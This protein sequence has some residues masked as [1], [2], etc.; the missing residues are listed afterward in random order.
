MEGVKSLQ[1][2]DH[3]KSGNLYGS[4][5]SHSEG[6]ESDMRFNYCAVVIERV[7]WKCINPGV[8]YDPRDST[9]IDKDALLEYCRGCRC[10]DGGVGLVPGLESHGGSYFTCLAT[11]TILDSVRSVFPSDGDV[12]GMKRWGL[13]RQVKGMQGRCNKKEDTCYSYWVGGGI[14]LLR[15]P[16]LDGKGAE[17][18][19]NTGSLSR[20][21]VGC[22]HGR[23]GGFGKTAD[24][25][26]DV[27]HTFYSLAYLAMVGG[28]E[29]I[30]GVSVVY[31]AGRKVGEW[32]EDERSYEVLK[33]VK[34][35]GE[36]G[37]G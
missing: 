9:Y 3:S 25:P 21:V 1:N 13:M 16:T 29:G 23:F 11:L 8:E 10:Y 5:S 26:P 7:L 24:A 14:E 31:G 32:I 18:M 34:E 27:L 4:F 19:L 28:T 36:K 35:Q 15:P 12:E 30:G 2:L 37:G 17:D 20:F 22:Q 6:S 33:R